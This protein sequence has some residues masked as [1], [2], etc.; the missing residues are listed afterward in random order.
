[1]WTKTSGGRSRSSRPPG[2]RLRVRL[3]FRARISRAEAPELCAAV[4]LAPPGGGA[5]D[6]GFAPPLRNARGRMWTVA[7]TS[8]RRRQE[9]VQAVE[10]AMRYAREPGADVDEPGAA[11]AV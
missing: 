5:P 6:A 10:W 9:L 2:V 1:M 7:A 3:R 11:A 8:L 4:G